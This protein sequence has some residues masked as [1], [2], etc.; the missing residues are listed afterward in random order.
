MTDN[1]RNNIYDEIDGGSIKSIL[2][3]IFSLKGG[4]GHSHTTLYTGKFPYEA[5]IAWNRRAC[6][7]PKDF[8]ANTWLRTA[9]RLSLTPDEEETDLYHWTRFIACSMEVPEKAAVVY[10]STL[11]VLSLCA[12][13]VPIGQIIRWIRFLHGEQISDLDALAMVRELYEVGL[14]L[15]QIRIAGRSQRN[16]GYQNGKGA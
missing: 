6:R 3:E 9:Q 5:F 16:E 14:L 1:Q 11:L 7:S 4:L 8:G 10:G 2:I 15:A 12:T 13:P